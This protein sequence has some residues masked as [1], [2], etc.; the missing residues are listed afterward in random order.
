V[1]QAALT[2]LNKTSS[3]FPRRLER[4]TPTQVKTL[5]MPNNK[6]TI[7]TTL[8]VT[9]IIAWPQD[10]IVTKKM[11]LSPDFAF[12]IFIFKVS[13][14][15]LSLG[16]LFSYYQL[17]INKPLLQGFFTLKIKFLFLA[18]MFYDFFK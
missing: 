15:D 10:L 1:A 6:A 16:K 12:N 11:R 3:C 14:R 18:K 7:T 4:S 9:S 8:K 13:F 17:F 2:V 5:I